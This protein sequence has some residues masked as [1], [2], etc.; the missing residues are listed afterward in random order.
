[1]IQNPLSLLSLGVG[2]DTE[3]ICLLLKMGDYH[4]LLDCGLEDIQPL[5]QGNYPSVDLVFCSHAHR[6]HAQGLFAFHQ[7]FPHIPIYSSK[8]TREFLA[9][10][11]FCKPLSLC[12][13]LPWRSPVEVA[14]N[15]TV[16]LFPAGHLPG[17]ASILLTYST[18]SRRYK[19]FYTGDFSLSKFQL[20]EGLSLEELRNT[21]IDVLIIEGSYGTA[22]YPHRRQ[23]EKKLIQQI[24]DLLAAQRNILFPVPTLGIGQEILKL[25][26]SHH[27][28]TG[29]DLDI[30]VDGKLI[31][32][33]DLYLKLLREFPSSVQ[34]FANHQPL[35]W[36]EQICPRMHRFS[37]INNMEIGDNPC[38]ILTD[39]IHDFSIYFQTQ[40]KEWTVLIPENLTLFFNE[41]YH[42]FLSLTQPQGVPLETYLLAEHSDGQNTTQLIHNLRPQHLIFIHGKPEYL[43]DLTSLE[44]LQ[45]RYQLHLPVMNAQVELPLG[46]RFIRPQN[47]P[48]AFYQG[49]IQETENEAIFQLSPDIQKDI[50]WQNLADTGLIEARWQ[51]NE[52]ILRGLSQRELFRYK[53]ENQSNLL[54]L[55]CCGSCHYQQNQQ[56][57]NLDSPLYGLKVP[58][59]G[60][61]PA[62]ESSISY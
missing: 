17:A 37:E 59:E 11:G 39:Q 44:E 30:W 46:E 19:V 10:Q 7:N 56:C 15:L 33:C 57:Y 9:L 38:I 4:I 41:K 25:L 21:A 51:G 35:F 31:Q 47:L 29:R 61:C 32:A 62:F 5:I 42:H 50:R 12:H 1:M 22:R 24:D 20:V 27:Q 8:V 52:L 36:D 16:E 3:G 6:D 55:D 34:N 13:V 43:A 48:Q 18:P 23:Q 2:H 60:Y 28:F 40:L 26:R 14:P 54:E 58:F 53:N 49:E 45:N